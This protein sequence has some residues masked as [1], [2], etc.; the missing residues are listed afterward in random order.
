M[1][2]LYD[3]G[4]R[5]S[6]GG[7]WGPGTVDP[8]FDRKELELP[9]RAPGGFPAEGSGQ[10]LGR[11]RPH[12][13]G[14]QLS[15][16]LQR[17]FPRRWPSTCPPWLHL[18]VWHGEGVRMKRGDG[19]GWSG[20]ILG[21]EAG[22]RC[23]EEPPQTPRRGRKEPDREGLGVRALELGGTRKLITFF[24]SVISGHVTLKRESIGPVS[25]NF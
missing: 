1:S 2:G 9:L 3:R 14:C 21:A 18:P 11:Q 7:G 19:L 6:T 12:L 15:V 4:P 13:P 23:L 24:C 20:L 10:G 25:L 17:P 8:A 5:L 16:L 22:S